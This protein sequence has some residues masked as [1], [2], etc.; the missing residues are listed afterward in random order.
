MGSSIALPQKMMAQCEGISAI[1]AHTPNNV[2]RLISSDALNKIN[3][4][5]NGF[6]KSKSKE[7]PTIDETK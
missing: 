1:E 3:D 5:L 7:L 6:E 2:S 4:G